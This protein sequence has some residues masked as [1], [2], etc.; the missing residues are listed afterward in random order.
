MT[1]PFPA[2]PEKNEGIQRMSKKLVQKAQKRN[3]NMKR[4]KVK[5]KRGRRERRIESSKDILDG[6]NEMFW[7]ESYKCWVKV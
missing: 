6:V 5:R 1:G 3:L 7:K 2:S 4:Q